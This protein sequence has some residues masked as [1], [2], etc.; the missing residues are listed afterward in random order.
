MCV[1]AHACICVCA[2][3]HV[4]IPVSLTEHVLYNSGNYILFLPV[5][6]ESVSLTQAPSDKICIYGIPATFLCHDLVQFLG[7]A[8]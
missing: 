8:Q 1:R 6:S 2:Y 7:P 3:M 5:N 4:N